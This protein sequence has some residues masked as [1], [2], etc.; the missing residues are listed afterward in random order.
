MLVVFA[1]SSSSKEIDFQELAI[2]A[3]KNELLDPNSFELIKYSLDTNYLHEE[4]MRLISNDSMEI[5]SAKGGL[6]IWESSKNDFG[7]DNYDEYLVQLKEAE[8]RIDSNFS[9][10]NNTTDSIV[11]YRSFIRYYANSKGGMR[12]INQMGVAFDYKGLVVNT[13]SLD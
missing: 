6:D 7:K 2:N 3:V 5:R 13:I 4:M 8:L 10:I 11:G 1:C 9:V 12:V